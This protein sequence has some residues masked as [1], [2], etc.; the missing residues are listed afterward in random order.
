MDALDQ[1]FK[2]YANKNIILKW[3]DED[4]S[5]LVDDLYEYFRSED[6]VTEFMA[7][8][9]DEYAQKYN[10]DF[11]EPEEF[12]ID[13]QFQP[14]PE[15]PGRAPQDGPKPGPAFEEKKRMMELAGLFEDEDEEEIE[16]EDEEEEEE[17]AEIARQDHVLTFNTPEDRD[18][19]IMYFQDP[20]NHPREV[21]KH[22]QGRLFMRP[23]D[24]VSII[25]PTIENR[26]K[27]GLDERKLKG[28]V[29]IMHR[30][31]NKKFPNS[32]TMKIESK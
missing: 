11:V 29:E 28:I 4:F 24:A 1:I 19:A 26:K 21:Q 18:Q 7:T 20:R 13:I 14:E 9:A 12:P 10:I 22:T 15:T 5:N 31:I 16:D 17:P 30:A 23:E 3:S 32:K 27:C 6:D 8:L 2:K 25:F